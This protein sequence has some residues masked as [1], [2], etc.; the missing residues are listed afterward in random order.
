MTFDNI[1]EYAIFH[2]VYSGMSHMH[3]HDYIMRAKSAMHGESMH[4]L[5]AIHY[6]IIINNII[7]RHTCSYS[8]PLVN[9]NII[10]IT[11]SIISQC[12]HAR[13]E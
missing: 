7:K 9:A 11:A 6:N 12:M 1:L 2:G 10:H 3:T 13:E 5:G 4:A 8:Q